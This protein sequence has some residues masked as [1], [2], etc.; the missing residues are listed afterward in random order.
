MHNISGPKELLGGL[1]WP[2]LAALPLCCIQ[3]P[4]MCPLHKSKLGFCLILKLL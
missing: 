2:V 3:F 4:I 1:N